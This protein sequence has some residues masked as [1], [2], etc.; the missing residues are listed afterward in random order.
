MNERSR[1]LWVTIFTKTFP[2]SKTYFKNVLSNV[3]SR[4]KKCH[5]SEKTVWG[6]SQCHKYCFKGHA[7]GHHNQHGYISGMMT[8]G[9][10]QDRNVTHLC[11]RSHSIIIRVTTLLGKSFSM[12]F[13]DQPKW[14]SITYQ[15]YIFC[16]NKLNM[17]YECI[18]ELVVTV[19]AGCS[20]EKC[21]HTHCS[22]SLQNFSVQ[23]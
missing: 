9:T 7:I 13:Q 5:V 11:S 2:G 3:M 22:H 16:R 20:S 14:I 8:S 17:T 12:T 23:L 10:V 15:H 18:S 6:T 1:W 19:P 21:L 4:L